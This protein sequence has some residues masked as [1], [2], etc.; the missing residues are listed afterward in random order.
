MNYKKIELGS[1]K[2]GGH[3]SGTA[4]E[5]ESRIY[6]KTPAM[7]PVIS[8]AS[9]YLPTYLIWT[10]R[11]D[12]YYLDLSRDP[13]KVVKVQ[14]PQDISQ[15]GIISDKAFIGKLNGKV[16]VYWPR[17]NSM[18]QLEGHA[19]SYAVLEKL[20]EEGT[21]TG[22]VVV[23]S[24][25]DLLTFVEFPFEALM[26]PVEPISV[27]SEKMP[28][29]VTTLYPVVEDDQYTGLLIATVCGLYARTS[30]GRVYRMEEV[31]GG[32]EVYI[33]SNENDPQGAVVVYTADNEIYGLSMELKTGTYYITE[34]LEV[35]RKPDAAS[36][37]YD[38]LALVFGNEIK[39][40]YLEDDN[41]Y[42]ELG[43][44]ELSFRPID[45]SL[46]YLK[47]TGDLRINL[48]W[49]KGV[50]T[51]YGSLDSWK[52]SK[53]VGLEEESESE[54]E[55][56]SQ[57]K[58]ES[59]EFALEKIPD[60]YDI[61]LVNFGQLKGF[62]VEIK[63]DYGYKNVHDWLQIRVYEPAGLP[64]AYVSFGNYLVRIY[65]C[66]PCA[67]DS[68]KEQKVKNVYSYIYILPEEPKDF[69]IGGYSG[70]LLMVGKSGKLYALYGRL[71]EKIDETH[72]KVTYKM[73]ISWDLNVEGVNLVG[74]R[75]V[76]NYIAWGDNKI[77]IIQY[78]SDYLYQALNEGGTL[79]AKEPIVVE[80][81]E[82]V[83]KVYMIGGPIILIKTE[84][85]IYVYD[86][87]G[88]RYEKGK[89]YKVLDFDGQLQIIQGNKDFVGYKNGKLYLIRIGVT[90]DKNDKYIP[91]ATVYSGP[92]VEGVVAFSGMYNTYITQIILGF[93]N[94]IGIYN[95]TMGDNSFTLKLDQEFSVPFT[96]DFVYGE[97]DCY[98]HVRRT[99]DYIYTWAGNKYY[100]LLGP[101]HRRW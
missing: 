92:K 51:L 45:I 83:E 68:L 52:N 37:S 63:G 94:K 98:C 79:E 20:N 69:T 47:A 1:P 96:P 61:K 33:I 44:I 99:A 49:D 85:S 72:Y 84:K 95:I 14:S 80:L 78:D 71:T 89:L 39:L 88:Y 9:Q 75:N 60:L 93:E 35:P 73:N 90:Y 46:S 8:E 82:K 13:Y 40:Y 5:F 12:V 64:S 6:G 101:D 87:M 11:G 66:I 100:L 76:Y 58:E 70:E 15:V 62:E 53:L 21:R 97:H 54:S 26:S 32:K 19:T 67:E 56:K 74:W 38:Y 16:V 25:D 81:P 3:I 18:L 65:T 86:I 41:A 4:I 23:Y 27:D 24:H 77:Y 22:V 50:G 42:R 91:K 2:G 59:R 57:V 43:S 48:I 30:E 55:S 28:C 7:T 34:P 36:I 31:F 17:D 29:T 10:E